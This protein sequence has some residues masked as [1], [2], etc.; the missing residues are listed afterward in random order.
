MTSV[1]AAGIE[2]ELSNSITR[3]VEAGVGAIE[4][5]DA[6]ATTEMM[7]QATD[8]GV[9]DQEFRLIEAD[10]KQNNRKKIK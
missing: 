3:V 4:E 7:D 8:E 2:S 9:V 5:A 1:N 10:K 6:T